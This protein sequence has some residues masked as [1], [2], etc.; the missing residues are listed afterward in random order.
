VPS[1]ASPGPN[2]ANCVR[3]RSRK[4]YSRQ[5]ITRRHFVQFL[6]DCQKSVRLS[7]ASGTLLYLCRRAAQKGPRDKAVT[8]LQR[9]PSKLP[10][11][12]RR[13]A[14]AAAGAAA[15]AVAGATPMGAAP[16]CSRT[17]ASPSPAGATVAARGGRGAGRGDA[18]RGHAAAAEEPELCWKCKQPGHTQ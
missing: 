14:G 11:P 12:P 5:V 13:R 1:E 6:M 4:P 16:C 9:P 17:A 2:Y 8:S 10:M 18:G 3:S 7:C 15:G